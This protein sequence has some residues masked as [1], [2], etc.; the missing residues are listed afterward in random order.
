MPFNFFKKSNSQSN[1]GTVKK[2]ATQ[3]D[4]KNFMNLT[5][6]GFFFIIII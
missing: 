2:A 3:N 1:R 6:T 4:Q 5:L